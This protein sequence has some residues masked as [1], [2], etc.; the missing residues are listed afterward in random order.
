MS[1]T[2]STFKT[3]ALGALVALAGAGTASAQIGVGPF[4]AFPT[5][6][7]TDARFLGFGCS[8]LATFEQGV[9]M[10]LAAPADATSF[11]VNLFDGDTGRPDGANRPHW[12][13][14]TRQLVYSLYAD[15][16]RQGSTAPAN[17][18]GQWFGNAM[19]PTSGALWTSSAAQMPD[20]DW[21]AVEVATSTSAQAPSG[22]YFYTLTIETDGVCNVGE[23]LKSNIKLAAS[24]PMSFLVPRFG[25]VAALRQINNDGPIVYPGTFPPP[26]GFVNAPT[27]YDGTF[28]FFLN[29]APGESDLAIWDGDFDF[30]TRTLVGAPSGTVLLPCLELD[31]LDTPANYSNAPFPVTGA[32]P[33]GLAG[34]GSPADDSNIDAF[35]RGEIGAPGRLGCV[36][37][38]VHDP[39]GVIYRNDNPSGSQEWEQFR[40][41]TSSAVNPA[42]S[43]HQVADATLP[44]GVWAVRTVGLDMSNLNFWSAPACA[45]QLEG[46]VNVAACPTAAVFLLGDTVWLDL[47]GDGVQDAGEPGIEGVELEL[48]P[49]GRTAPTQIVATGDEGSGNWTACTLMNTGLDELGLYCFGVDLADTYTVSVAASNFAP[50]GPLEGLAATTGGGNTQTF[51]LTDDNVLTFD[52]G[53]RGTAGLGDRVWSDADSDGVQDV[54]EIGINSVTVELLDGSNTVIATTVTMGDGDYFFS[55]LLPGTYTVRV[56][57]STLPAGVTP[58]FDLDGTGTPNTATLTLAPGALRT[59]VDFGYRNAP[60][61]PGTGTI[62]YWKNHSEAWPVQTITVGGVT[63]TKAQAISL[64]ATPGKGDKTY[65]LYKQ[66]VAAKL[67]VIIGNESS[68]IEATIAAA[69]AWLAANPVGSGV[70]S[71]SEAWADGGPL[72][73]R[74]DDYNNGRLCAP[75]RG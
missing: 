73:K 45:N 52:F 58:T 7:T 57:T 49:S 53:F 41:A 25:I 11:V 32:N 59:D 56:V 9:S 19:N 35:R 40:I 29:V 31:D 74:L 65:D 28:E 26:A 20:N 39:N 33:E 2:R 51:D 38:E 66:L 24:A 64:M 16:L 10:G 21:W 61:N 18:I 1:V 27:T 6:S 34:P 72:H 12:D 17:L 37:Y 44:A 43:D 30:G 22:N 50:G 54:G 42:D 48:T 8:G 4:A 71:S 62:G 47:D 14:G 5:Q 60:T 23:Q 3:I 46:G 13:L 36:R 69:D 55:D 68:C 70:K 15:P 63:Y 67:N 75:H